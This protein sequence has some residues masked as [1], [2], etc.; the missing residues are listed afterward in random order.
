MFSNLACRQGARPALLSLPSRTGVPRSQSLVSAPENGPQFC[1][2]LSVLASP[3]TPT[4][5]RSRKPEKHEAGLGACCKRFVIKEVKMSGFLCGGGSRDS[6]RKVWIKSIGTPERIGGIRVVGQR[7]SARWYGSSLAPSVGRGSTRQQRQRCPY[8]SKSGF[9]GGQHFSNSNS[10]QVT[11]M[12]RCI[13][14][15]PTFRIWSNNGKLMYRLHAE[16]NTSGQGKK[17]KWYVGS[18]DWCAAMLSEARVKH[19]NKE[20]QRRQR[21][22]L[23]SLIS[24]PV[25][26]LKYWCVFHVLEGLSF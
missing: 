2:T 23:Y 16:R 26:H 19:H 6:A 7:S 25:L 11:T 4:S 17:G 24:T 5:C 14:N 8:S 3:L 13:L 10:E 12:S 1:S 15:D 21:V 20:I 9:G 18:V 22:F